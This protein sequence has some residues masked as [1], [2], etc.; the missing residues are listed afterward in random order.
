MTRKA[1]LSYHSKYSDAARAMPHITLYFLQ[2]SR[3]IRVAWLLE[4]LELPYDI[5]FAD[6]VANK[7]PTDFK[8]NSPTGR[9]P[10]IKDGD[11]VVAE[12]GAIVE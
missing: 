2:A 10:S 1:N 7:A 8:Q 4:L 5:E 3:S 11:L 6:R 12:S 9:F